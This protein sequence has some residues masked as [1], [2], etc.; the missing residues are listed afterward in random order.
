MTKN[1]ETLTFKTPS[2]EFILIDR[3]PAFPFACDD[4]NCC[5]QD[6]PKE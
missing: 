4:E 3:H 6:L 2:F 1:T 5:S